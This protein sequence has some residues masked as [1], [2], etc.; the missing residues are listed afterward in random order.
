MLSGCQREQRERCGF[1]GQGEEN[2][3]GNHRANR[4]RC[5]TRRVLPL[6]AKNGGVREQLAPV[7]FVKALIMLSK[8]ADKHL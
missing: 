3:T 2:R 5:Q 1:V 4:E 7:C 8:E 6:Q